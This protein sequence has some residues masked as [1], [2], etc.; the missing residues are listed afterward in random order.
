MYMLLHTIWLSFSIIIYP[1]PEATLFSPREVAYTLH[2]PRQ[3]PRLLSA[4]IVEPQFFC[5][6]NHRQSGEGNARLPSTQKIE[7]SCCAGSVGLFNWKVK[8]NSY[9]MNRLYGRCSNT[10]D[11]ISPMEAVELIGM[12]TND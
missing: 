10:G 9:W 3:V 6:A 7:I 8:F 5:V 11:Y 2:C 12:K 4:S 1:I